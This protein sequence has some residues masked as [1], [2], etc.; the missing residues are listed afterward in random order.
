MFF[1]CH[2]C[3]SRFECDFDGLDSAGDWTLVVSDQVGGDTGT[4]DAWSLRFTAVDGPPCDG[5]V[6]K[7]TADLTR[8]GNVGFADL[9]M[10]L[11]AW[12]RAERGNQPAP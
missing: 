4:L 3:L 11:T 5:T 8:D 6:A 1:A 9:E 10:V 2:V 12:T 7:C